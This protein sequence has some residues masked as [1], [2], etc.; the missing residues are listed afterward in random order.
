MNLFKTNINSKVPEKMK[1]IYFGMGCFWGA[2]KRFWDSKGVYT[3]IV[4][5]SG[6][7]KNNPTYDEVCS[8]ETGHAE[9]VS[10]IYDKELIKILDL[11]KIFWESH[12]PTQYNRQGN[13]IGSQYRSAIYTES[14][15]DSDLAELTKFKY[16]KLLLENG[17][18]EIKTEISLLK[19]FY[20]A[21]DYH[22]KYLHKNPNGYCGLQGTG[23]KFK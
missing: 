13:D 22:Q 4:G 20:F 19:N 3:T 12:D 8:G 18:K 11:L 7:C 23:V 16:Q 15:E 9:V 10:V 21:E 1:K 14:K 2:E 5:Y 6:G 17:F